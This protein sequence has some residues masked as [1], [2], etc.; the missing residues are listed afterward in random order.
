[1]HHRPAL[2]AYLARLQLMAGGKP[3]VLGEFGIDSLREGEQR[4]AVAN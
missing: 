4:K 1:L 3:L 2:R